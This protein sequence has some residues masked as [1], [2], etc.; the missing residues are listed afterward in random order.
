MT[1]KKV[2][3]EKRNVFK[4]DPTCLFDSRLSS[5]AKGLHTFMM[6][7]NEAVISVK[8]LTNC[9]KNG[10]DSVRR[11]LRELSQAGYISTKHIRD[12]KGR[13]VHLEYTVHE[14]PTFGSCEEGSLKVKDN[15]KDLSF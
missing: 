4:L 1:F 11:I 8:Y 12:E 14:R 2:Y 10:R 6:S 9:S 7:R 3:A 13:H 5:E 15:Q